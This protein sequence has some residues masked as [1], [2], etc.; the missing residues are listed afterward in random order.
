M[1]T[2]RNCGSQL[3]M[4]ALLAVNAALTSSGFA[5]QT[6]PPRATAVRVTALAAGN[7]G[8]AALED[9]EREIDKQHLRQIYKAIEAYRLKH[10]TLPNWL[11]DLV[12]EYLPDAA[13]LMSPVELRTGRSV[14]W[15]YGDPKV[16]SSYI[17]EFNQSAAGGI[18][19]QDIPL[20]MKQWKEL[21][22]DEFGPAIPLLRCHLH[23][24]I[25]NVSF[26]GELYE[27]GLFWETNS[28]T[29]ALMARLG[30]GPGA[31]EGRK[32]RLTVVDGATAQPLGDAEVE[33]T[34]RSSEFGWL[35]PR[36]ASTDAKGQCELNLGG[37][38]PKGVNLKIGKAGYANALRQFGEGDIPEE[39]SVKLE[40]AA[41]IGGLVRDEQG[42]PVAG[43]TV[44]VSGLARD[45][46]GQVVLLEYDSASTDAAGKWASHRVPAN[47]EGLN[48]KLAHPEF[49][50]GEYDQASAENPAGKV[51]TRA[52]LLAGTAALVLEPGIEVRG[53]VQ[54]RNGNPI[55][56]AQVLLLLAEEER[57]TTKRMA[58]DASGNFRFV[59]TESGD[60]SL[61]VEAEGFAPSR[62][63]TEAQRGARPHL[64]VLDKGRP[65]KGRVLDGEGNP[66]AGVSISV[67]SFENI[68][69]L[70]W[71]TQ[72]DAEGWFTWET[73]PDSE[74]TLAFSKTGFVESFVQASAGAGSDMS[75][76]LDR[77]FSLSGKVLD[78]QT[79]EPIRSF[80][81]IRGYSYGPGEDF[82]NWDRNEAI[83]GANGRYSVVSSDRRGAQIKYMLTAEGF[84]PASSPAYEEKGAH[85]FDFELK[86][87]QGLSGVVQ[88]AGGEPVSGA[89]VVLAENRGGAYMDKEGEFR[90]GITQGQSVQT[91]EQGRF[92]FDPSLEARTVLAAHERGFAQVPVDKVA[93]GGK[94]VLE[95][96]GRVKG[97]VKVGQPRPNR[98]VALNSV[99]YRYGEDGHQFPALQLWLRADPKEDGSF[100]FEKVPPGDRKLYVQYKFS[101]GPGRIP[102]S[103]GT[104]VCVKPGETAEV[105]IGGGGRPVVGRVHPVGA[106]P[107]EVDWAQGVQ[108]L[109]D[110]GLEAPFSRTFGS[111]EE[112][113]KAFAEYSQ[114]Q[115]AFWSS[116]A[117][118]ARERESKDYVLVF[119]EDGSFRVDAVPPGSYT[120]NISPNQSI[121][122]SFQQRYGLAGVGRPIG[123]LRKEI[124]VPAA[125]EGKPDD[126]FDLGTLEVKLAPAPAPRDR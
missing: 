16:K 93:A 24:P 59:L 109:E 119:A 88:S 55:A 89:T 87:G 92:K 1:K 63:A 84:L 45:P 56:G 17:Y 31:R 83:P 113:Q 32:L 114:K 19:D 13:V 7:A 120:L 101:D 90:A 115:R 4:A 49:M 2:N 40:K 26:S 81:L 122:L 78:A 118:R 102:L 70:G 94:V 62:L 18:R 67:P 116:A 44:V 82:V 79:G 91:D 80:K 27:S 124:V 10:G 86:P 121:D 106:E 6:N 69:P 64:V 66:L 54:E 47:F 38:R 117:G 99:N 12:P 14:L 43:V 30:P 68:A 95:P 97:I 104:Y 11:A 50:P 23:D 65:L 85:T 39:A 21:Q 46:V 110:S 76:R 112:R 25:L 36:R 77:P 9:E 125:P 37:K 34:G 57:S 48:F 105:V 75:V 3:L 126:P 15:G 28:N 33:A 20:T 100:V 72:T 60:V 42:K 107:A 108:T 41:S 51:L 52:S 111:N 58:A 61:L 5:A 103:H 53:T 35:P 22:M 74:V 29:L 8:A 96:W 73:A 98:W 71:H 123:N